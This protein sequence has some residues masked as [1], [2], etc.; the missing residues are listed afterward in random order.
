[1]T[2]DGSIE[3]VTALT[4][5]QPI[6]NASSLVYSAD[7]APFEFPLLSCGVGYTVTI[8]VPRDT[9]EAVPIIGLSLVPRA[10]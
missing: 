3:T 7:G 6:R 1:M 5:N 2:L 8:D 9:D 4:Q 10:A